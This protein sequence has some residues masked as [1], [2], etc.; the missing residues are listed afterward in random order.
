[1][2]SATAAERA[3][4]SSAIANI[5]YVRLSAVCR[6]TMTVRVSLQSAI[7]YQACRTIVHI[8]IRRGLLGPAWATARTYVEHSLLIS[9]CLGGRTAL[10]CSALS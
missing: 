10:I 7:I 3:D 1:M 4:V 8:F 9:L 2:Q 6:P 5:D